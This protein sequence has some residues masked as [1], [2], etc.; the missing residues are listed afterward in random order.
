MVDLPFRLAKRTQPLHG[1]GGGAASSVLVAAKLAYVE[2]RERTRVFIY[3]IAVWNG[4]RKTML[5]IE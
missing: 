2:G 1:F 5:E 3:R 4:L